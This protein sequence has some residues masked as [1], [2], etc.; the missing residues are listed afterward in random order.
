MCIPH[1]FV[2]LKNMQWGVRGKQCSGE[3]AY[4]GRQVYSQKGSQ[5]IDNQLITLKSAN[6]FAAT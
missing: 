4:V 3:P 5:L 6:K 2:I 1:C